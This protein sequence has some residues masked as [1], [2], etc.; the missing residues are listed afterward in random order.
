M[1][2][3]RTLVVVL[4][5]WSFVTALG[6]NN[7]K[8]RDR[9]CYYDRESGT[10]LCVN[11]EGNN[12]CHY[13]NIGN[14]L[15]W[16]RDA[17]K[18]GLANY[19]EGDPLKMMK[20]VAYL[21]AYARKLERR[22][23]GY[24]AATNAYCALM[25]QKR[26]ASRGC[27]E[28]R[29]AC[30]CCLG[31]GGARGHHVIH[32]WSGP[33]SCYSPDLHDV[34]VSAMTGFEPAPDYLIDKCNGRKRYV[35]VYDRDMVAANKYK[36]AATSRRL[37]WHTWGKEDNREC[38]GWQQ[39]SESNEI[40]RIDLAGLDVKAYVEKLVIEMDADIEE[41][42][43]RRRKE[44][45]KSKLEKDA[46]MRKRLHDL[47][48]RQNLEERGGLREIRRRIDKISNQEQRNKCV[49][50]AAEIES[51]LHEANVPGVWKGLFFDKDGDGLENS[52][53][54]DP[55]VAGADAHGTNAEW[56]NI[57]CS[58]VL[59]AAVAQGRT[60]PVDLSWRDGV[61]SNAYYFV[62]VVTER[63]P[64]P[65]WFV[66]DRTCRLGDPAVMALPDVTNR[67]PLLI[68]IDYFV[69]SD[70]PFKISFPVD[71]KYP[72]VETNVLC[73]A[74]I[75]WPL[76]FVF[77]ETIEGRKRVYKVSVEPY[78]PGGVFEWKKPDTVRPLLPL[79]DEM[80]F[81]KKGRQK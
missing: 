37:S 53:D 8:A 54:P 40:Y 2:T 43:A 50:L 49:K 57:V 63:V 23:Q 44:I 77:R 78:D 45:E 60:P 71:Y 55:L 51:A 38:V 26:C 80:K 47:L 14:T 72:E 66:G 36:S 10:P 52:V 62:D 22:G 25:W 65:I 34:P 56:Y 1:K 11:Q 20:V 30:Y 81:D 9:H 69:M 46:Y 67:V 5:C 3:L 35:R 28:A 39:P 13:L 16:Q 19:S 12:C 18:E 61:N 15:I 17:I 6:A 41:A 4:S 21:S 74:R 33:A 42:S 32:A 59:V 70:T 68:G 64:A 7:A 75:H 79:A 48:A 31:F 58:N 27:D 29:V 24:A 73:T 76:R